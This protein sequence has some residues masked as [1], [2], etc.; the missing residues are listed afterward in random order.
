MMEL[1]V[2]LAIAGVVAAVALPSTARTVSDLRLSGDA[3]TLH[4]MVGLAKMRAAARFTR[5]RI[6]VDR[7]TGTYQMQYWDKVN[8]KWVSESPSVNTL[9]T[10][11]QFG[12]GS[13]NTPPPNTQL[14]IG[15]SPACTNDAGTTISNTS[16]IIFNTRGIPVTSTGAI[17]G[18]SGLYITDGVGTYAVTLS[19]TPLIRLWWTKA[20]AAKW[21]KR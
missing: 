20:S 12:Y 13:L 4:N 17:T 18:N 14:A 8:S 19:A 1:L 6:F 9:S 2:T 10:G 7:T 15:Q 21:I 3:R 16:C 5:E 11:V